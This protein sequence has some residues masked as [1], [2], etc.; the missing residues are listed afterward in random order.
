MST[1]LYSEDTCTIINS[2]IRPRP[3]TPHVHKKLAHRT[4]PGCCESPRACEHR[5]ARRK[6]S[7]DRGSRHVVDNCFLA[8]NTKGLF[9]PVWR[10]HWC[11]SSILLTIIYVL[12][13]D[14]SQ[15]NQTT[16]GCRILYCI[17]KLER[18]RRGKELVRHQPSHP[19]TIIPVRIL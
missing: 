17:H 15:S 14:L 10:K 12:Y 8:I 9:Y 4:D 11:V 3:S 7:C 18:R 2:C 1:D 13:L 6:N 16:R 5:R 19:A